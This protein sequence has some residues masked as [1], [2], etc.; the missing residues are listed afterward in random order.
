MTGDNGTNF[1]GWHFFRTEAWHFP[2]GVIKKY[3]YP[4]GTDV[5]FT[6]SIPLLA[7]SFKLFNDFLPKTFQYIGLW[8]LTP[9]GKCHASVLKKCQPKKLVP[10]SPVISHSTWDGSIIL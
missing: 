1:L 6:G 4:S 7:I 10:L 5:V 8:L 3:H 9:K 2:L